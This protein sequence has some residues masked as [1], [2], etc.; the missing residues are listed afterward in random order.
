MVDSQ[1]AALSVRRQGELLGLSPSSVDYAALSKG[2][3]KIFN[4]DQCAQFTADS[5][6]ACLL[7]AN[8][9]VSIDDLGRGLDDVCC[10]RLWRSF[11]CENIYLNQ[12]DTVRQLRTGLTA[13]FD[14]YN[15][16][17]VGEGTSC[18]NGYFFPKPPVKPDVIVSRHPAFS[19]L[20][21]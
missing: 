18:P 16:G 9:R 11:K 3:P 19:V 7:A 14:V 15:P 20:P 12:Y 5:F 13:Y 2:R 4:T 10:E 17:W 8:I 1:H 6:T 21:R